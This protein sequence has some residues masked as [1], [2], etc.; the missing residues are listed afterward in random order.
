MENKEDY[1][2]NLCENMKRT[3]HS[4]LNKNDDFVDHFVD[5][6]LIYSKRR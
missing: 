5:D 6:I 1:K 2:M 4:I 3:L